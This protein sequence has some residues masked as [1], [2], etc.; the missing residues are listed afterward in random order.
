MKD[1]PNYAGET[2]LPRPINQR[3]ATSRQGRKGDQAVP[4]PSRLTLL[5]ASPYCWRMKAS[6]ATAR[7][8]QAEAGLGEKGGKNPAGVGVR[9]GIKVE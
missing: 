7:S 9:E 1:R 4:D 2:P 6:R 3:H 5:A 8:Y